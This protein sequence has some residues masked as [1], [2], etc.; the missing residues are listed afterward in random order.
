MCV[1]ECVF[2]CVC[3]RIRL[4][5]LHPSAMFVDYGFGINLLKK[6]DVC[7]Y[8]C[9]Y[10]AKCAQTFHP[11]TLDSAVREGGGEERRSSP[12]GSGGRSGHAGDCRSDIGLIPLFFFCVQYNVTTTTRADEDTHTQ[13]QA[14]ATQ[15]QTC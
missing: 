15:G 1:C 11:R 8:V 10:N 2:A 6:N 9:I 13:T 12:A 4:G 7:V 3:V 5:A 14:R